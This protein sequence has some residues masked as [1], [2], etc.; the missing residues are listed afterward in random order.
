MY[1]WGMANG[2]GDYQ[3]FVIMVAASFQSHMIGAL[4]KVVE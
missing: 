1:I 3:G 4:C 2:R